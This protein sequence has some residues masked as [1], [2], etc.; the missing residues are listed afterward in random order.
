MDI[1]CVRKCYYS[2]KAY[3]SE[4]LCAQEHHNNHYSRD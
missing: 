2:G 1:D 4:R 3:H